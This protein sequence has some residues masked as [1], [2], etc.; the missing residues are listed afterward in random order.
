MMIG[1]GRLLELSPSRKASITPFAAT[2][3]LDFWKRWHISLSLWFRDYC[4]TPI[5]KRMVKSGIKDP[6]LATL[7]AYFISFGLLGLWHGRTWPF[8]LCGLMFAAGSSANHFYRSFLNRHGK[9]S[10]EKLGENQLY[11]ALA[12]SI[13]FFYISIAI[14]GLWLSGDAFDKLWRSF[15]LRQIGLSFTLAIVCLTV[16]LYLGRWLLRMERVQSLAIKPVQGFF[17]EETPFLIAAKAFIF[18]AWFFAFS[19]N[20]P[21]FVYQRF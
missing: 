1:L 17:I 6:A 11:Q 8:V 2:S 10:L 9:G 16:V 15:S 5:L 18:V 21:D 4:L 3:F 7:P 13:T 19:A 20:L 12:S 14:T